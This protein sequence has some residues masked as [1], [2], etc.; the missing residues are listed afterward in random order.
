MRGV[1]GHFVG[2]QGLGGSLRTWGAWGGG[3]HRAWLL[4]TSP[5]V[6]SEKLRGSSVGW[7]KPAR[8]GVQGWS[9]GQAASLLWALVSPSG[10]SES[11]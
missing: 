2:C 3:H 9:V 10:M 11:A 4:R 7:G 6:W 1:E 8:L 5:A